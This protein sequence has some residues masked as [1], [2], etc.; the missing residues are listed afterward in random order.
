MKTTIHPKWY[1]ESQVSC[2]CGNVFTVGSTVASISVN[3]CSK[4]HPFFTGEQ[5]FVDTEGR[6]EKFQKKQKEAVEKQKVI[7]EKK[8]KQATKEA[9]RPK[10]LREM[11]LGH[12]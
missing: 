1:P 8:K 7:L 6:V 11:L 4:C 9:Y 3:T 5:K 10:T 12:Q 2:I